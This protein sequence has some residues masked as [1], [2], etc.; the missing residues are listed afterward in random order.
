M[1]GVVSDLSQATSLAAA[2][3]GMLG[4]NGSLYSGLPFGMMT[5]DGEQKRHIDRILREQFMKVKTLLME[6]RELTVAIAEEVL[7]KGDLTYR[8]LMS[9][10]K[11]VE[12][13]RLIAELDEAPEAAPALPSGNGHTA[14]APETEEGR[15]A[16]YDS[17]ERALPPAREPGS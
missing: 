10:V 8:E 11:G 12:D 6:N 9:I 2:M 17:S 15:I 7:E 13:K 4:M 14:P 16:A 3:V 5:P 1:N